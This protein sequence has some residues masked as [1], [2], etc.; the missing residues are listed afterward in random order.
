MVLLQYV[1]GLDSSIV[2]DP[3]RLHLT[4]SVMA[5]AAVGNSDGNTMTVQAALDLPHILRPSIAEVLESQWFS[6]SQ[7]QTVLKSNKVRRET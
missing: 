3:R 5:L 1:T 7:S 6:I 2:I 4:L